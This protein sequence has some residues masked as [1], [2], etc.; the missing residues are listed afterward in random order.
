MQY[1][2]Q[3]LTDVCNIA[4]LEIGS[5][6]ISDMDDTTS[7]NAGY[8]R[9]AFWQAFR[10]VARMHDWNCL[11]KRVPLALLGS[12]VTGVT[13]PTAP[14]YWQPNTLY[15]ATAA[16]TYVTYG[17]ATYLC[18][19]TATSSSNF[20]NDLTA[21]LWAQ[22]FMP[23]TFTMAFSN[24]SNTPGNAGTNYEWNYAYGLPSDFLLLLELNGNSCANHRGVGDLYELYITQVT[25]TDETISSIQ[26]LY[27]NAAT[28]VIKYIALIQDPSIWD[29]L[30]SACIGTLL[31]SKI[32]TQIRGDGGATEAALLQK[33]RTVTL[34]IARVQD[35]GEQ[36]ERRY[37]PTKESKFLRARYGGPIS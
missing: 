36:K 14:P 32:A 37:D 5:Q 34:P 8:C 18:M 19:V 29:P 26:S 10:E 17:T 6:P 25:N 31:A 28:A 13:T 22:N 33:F 21:G 2:P 4:L 11:T 15:T 16:G 35:G 20:I 27:C 3:S 24:W 1:S 12:T 23:N 9:Q 7:T 30:F